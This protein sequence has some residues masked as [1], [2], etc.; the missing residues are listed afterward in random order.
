MQAS[1]LALVQFGQLRLGEHHAAEQMMDEVSMA[2]E[3]RG[4]RPGVLHA[5]PGF[6]RLRDMRRAGQ[7]KTPQRAGPLIAVAGERHVG[8]HT[9]LRRDVTQLPREVQHSP[10]PPGIAFLMHPRD[11]LAVEPHQQ[12]LALATHERCTALPR[13]KGGTEYLSALFTGQSLEKL[14]KAGYQVGLGQHQVHRQ[15]DA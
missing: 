9:Q 7:I 4:H 11:D 10:A 1:A 8:K 3:H 2:R 13:L 5:S 6:I 12:R 15:L 14:G